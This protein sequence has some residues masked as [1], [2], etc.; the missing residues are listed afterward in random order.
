MWSSKLFLIS[1]GRAFMEHIFCV[2]CNVKLCYILCWLNT[3]HQPCFK[4][5]VKNFKM[6]HYVLL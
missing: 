2:F 5:K 3:A 4:K 1:E 6:S